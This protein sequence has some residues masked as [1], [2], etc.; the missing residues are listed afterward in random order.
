[1]SIAS[2]INKLEKLKLYGM[3][4]ALNGAME[5]GISGLSTDELLAYIVDAEWEYRHNRKLTKLIKAAK[6]RYSASI[7]EINFT[8]KRNFDKNCLLPFSDCSWIEKKQNIIITGPTGVGK[9]YVSAAI[10]HQACV[11]GF[12]TSYFNFGKLIPVL[13][14]KK[15][16]GSYLKEIRRIEK[17][18]V[19]VLDDFGLEKLDTVSRLILLEILE[20][21]HGIKSTIITSQLPVAA[22]HDVIGDPTISDAICDRIV[23]NCHRIEL[24]GPSVRKTYNNL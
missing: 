6:F 13:K 8:I 16:D 17:Q 23:H 22:W 1:M 7:E 5:A 21:R 15:A 19:L 20:D 14:L 12:K 24:D 9:S 18:D 11:Y 2:T 10:G 4:R 3:V